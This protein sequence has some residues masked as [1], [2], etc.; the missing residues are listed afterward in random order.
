MKLPPLAAFSSLPW[1]SSSASPFPPSSS[2]AWSRRAAAL[3]AP[4]RRP[5]SPRGGGTDIGR[6]RDV[7]A[8]RRGRRR[9]SSSAVVVGGGGGRGGIDNDEGEGNDDVRRRTLDA[10]LVKM[11]SIDEVAFG[12]WFNG[13]RMRSVEVRE[14]SI[15]GAGLGLF[16]KSSIRSGTII[17][18]YPV[19]S[20][21][22]VDAV[23]GGVTR[24]YMDAGTGRT[25]ERPDDDNGGDGDDDND[26]DNDNDEAYLLHVFGGRPLM[27]AD[28][29]RDL[30]G[31]SIFVDV[32]VSNVDPRRIGE[33][34]TIA[35]YGFDGHRVNDGATVL[36]N[37]EDGALAYYRAS[38]VARNCVHVP[39][40][41]SPLLACVS[42]RKIRKGDEL[43]TTYG[44]S[45]E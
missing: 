30:G 26:N 37:D 41:P 28:V 1:G 31:R 8:G 40:G 14:S 10:A 29:S 25:Y 32:D 39:F 27:D 45:C 19:H 6:H 35:S 12:S 36:T 42:T 11:R 4:S 2:F 24:V 9:S 18:F 33:D 20:I 13:R 15:P 16:A 23:D 44:C 5:S 22:I 7:D 3:P 17:T 34:G 21:G 38:R 43:L